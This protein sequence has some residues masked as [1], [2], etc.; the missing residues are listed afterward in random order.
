MC[1]EDIRI[2]LRRSYRITP[3]NPV[4]GAVTFRASGN[5]V[6][7]KVSVFAS[8]AV[9]AVV[10]VAPSPITGNVGIIGINTANP[11]GYLSLESHGP[12][13]FGEFVVTSGNANALVLEVFDNELSRISAGL[14]IEKPR[15]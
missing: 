15:K 13:I 12:V 8:S 6:M 7:F 2:A 14:P 1:E 10:S 3:V 9:D 11:D 5:R 4:T